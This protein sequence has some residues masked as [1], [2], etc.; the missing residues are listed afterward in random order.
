VVRSLVTFLSA[1]IARRSAATVVGC[2]LG[3][4]ACE[5]GLRTISSPYS[6]WWTSAPIDSDRTSG[7]AAS[8]TKWYHEGFA[9]SHFSVGG[10]RLTGNPFIDGA[11][12]GVILG[13]S[14]VRAVQVDDRDTMGSALERIARAE[15]ISLNVRQYGWPAATPAGFVARA[16]AIL[17]RWQPAWIAV[18]LTSSVA[19][20]ASLSSPPTARVT[21][22]TALEITGPI[23]PAALRGTPLRLAIQS[24]T[25]AAAR[26]SVL[27]TELVSRVSLIRRASDPQSEGPSPSVDALDAEIVVDASVRSLARAFGDRLLIVFLAQVAATGAA[28]EPAEAMIMRACQA[29]RVACLSTRPAMIALRD[30][31]SLLAHGFK[32]SD[33]GAGHLNA[34]G[35]ALVARTMWNLL[36]ERTP[37]S[38]V[39]STTR[40]G[41]STGGR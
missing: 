37:P 32:N 10:A 35:H 6:E 20:P 13:D 4:L 7:G 34:V 24:I 12:V 36:R 17:H 14:H 1:P 22:D 11:P 41:R 33:I 28:V 39:T 19:V 40:A 29:Q 18:I 26:H 21:A 15:S 16:P 23:T 9:T 31:S 5:V 8:T 2:V 27:A 3:L 30:S 25:L 38:G